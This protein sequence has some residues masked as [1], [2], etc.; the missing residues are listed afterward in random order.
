M[1]EAERLTEL[2]A[3]AFSKAPAPE[4]NSAIGAM[5]ASR[6]PEGL[7]PVSYELVLPEQD[8]VEFLVERA[9]PRLVYY[10]T[11]RGIRP[12]HPGSMFVSLFAG[13]A[14]YFINMAEFLALL[15]RWAGASLVELSGR[16]GADVAG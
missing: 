16:Y 7:L 14:L 11:S 3:A 2:F 5:R 13:D 4:A 8:A 6:A 12:E 10:L 9:M 1:A 15:A